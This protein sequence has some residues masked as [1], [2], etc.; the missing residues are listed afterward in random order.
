[1]LKGPLHYQSLI[2][3]PCIWREPGNHA[4]AGTT[5]ADL[6]SLLDLPTAILSR[7]GVAPVYGM[8]GRALFT[9]AGAVQAS[10]RDAVLIEE[11]QQRAYLGFKGTVRVR[12]L[13][14]AT[15][16]ISVFADGR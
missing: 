2:G 11:N 7:A 5:R 3:V 16:R 8:Q 10:G 9:P 4:A 1:M 6:T 13:V 12:T 14:T 15:H